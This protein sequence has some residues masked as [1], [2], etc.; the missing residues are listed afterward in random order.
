MEQRILHDARLSE[1]LAFTVS[2]I[3]TECYP[4]VTEHTQEL[5]DRAV[6]LQDMMITAFALMEQETWPSR[7]TGTS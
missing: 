6:R 1:L 4:G 2:A 3:M 5:V 7:H